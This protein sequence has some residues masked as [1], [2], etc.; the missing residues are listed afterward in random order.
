MYSDISQSNNRQVREDH[1]SSHLL[2]GR[3]AATVQAV[4]VLATIVHEATDEAVVA[5]HDAGHLGDVL[6][7]LVLRDVAAVIHQ[8]GNQVALSSLL[9]RTFFYLNGRRGKWLAY[10]TIYLSYTL[11]LH[12]HQRPVHVG[13]K[14]KPIHD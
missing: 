8:A 12:G 1:E 10:V 7:A 5:E 3:Y 2:A 4:D 9:C 13:V 11:S 6:V 14:P